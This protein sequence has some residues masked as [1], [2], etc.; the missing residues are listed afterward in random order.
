MKG[1]EIGHEMKVIHKFVKDRHNQKVG[2]LVGV[3]ANGQFSIGCSKV[4]RSA[5]DTFDKDRGMEIATK[6]AVMGLGNIPSSCWEDYQFFHDRCSR[7][8]RKFDEISA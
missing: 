3:G 2:V 5:G 4:N 6:R 8:F 1:V 7:Y